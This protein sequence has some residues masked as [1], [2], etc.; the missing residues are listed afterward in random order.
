MTTK[1]RGDCEFYSAY[2]DTCDYTLLMYES[3]GCPTSACTK[4]RT[5]TKGRSWNTFRGAPPENAKLRGEEDAMYG[6]EPRD[7]GDFYERYV[8]ADCGHEVYDGE[9]LYEWEDGRSLCPECVE[10]KFDGL[11]T[12]EKAALLGCEGAE[13]GFPGRPM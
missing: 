4:Y 8:I 5:R 2:T 7:G 12:A 6:P 10:G 1:C 11:S 3:R 9:C 13:V